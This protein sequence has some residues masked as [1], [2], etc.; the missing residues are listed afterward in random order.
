LGK[1]EPSS[2]SRLTSLAHDVA[3]T[4]QDVTFGFAYN[5]ASQIYTRTTSNDSYAWGGHGSGSTT[6]VPDGLN[7]LATVGGTSFN[8]DTKG[9][10]ISDGSNA[11]SYSAE[12]LLTS[13]TNPG[14]LSTATTMKYD[15]LGRLQ[16]INSNYSGFWAE[17]SR[18][19]PGRL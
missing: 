1:G 5:P 2:A 16:Q 17:W 14:S 4:A 13:L 10:L 12:N 7:R 15:P 11:Y 6:A 18:T 19:R 8:Y 9:N 3:G